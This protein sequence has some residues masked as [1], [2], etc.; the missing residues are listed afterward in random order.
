MEQY[1]ILLS[2][3]DKQLEIVNKLY[4]EI[5]S[6]DLNI[7]EVRYMFALKTQQLYTALEDLFKQIAKAFENHIKS[8]EN[9]H[10][11]LLQRMNT[12]IPKIRPAVLSKKSFL[13]LDKVRSFR[14]FIRHAYDCELDPQEL[15]IIQDK[16]KFEF[17]LVE[18][19]FSQ[20]R[21][22]VQELANQV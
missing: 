11:E 22:F 16:M 6:A 20:F 5:E 1:A 14:H 15:Q 7:Y 13:F 10:K 19:D 2:Y 21:S 9:Y 12:D 4:L 8:L 17:T 3:Y 18:Q